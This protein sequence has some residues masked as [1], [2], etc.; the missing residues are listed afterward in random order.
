MKLFAKKKSGD[1]AAPDAI[2]DDGK[3]ELASFTNG[4]LLGSKVVSVLVLVAIACGPVAIGMITAR[5]QA[6]APV[7]AATEPGEL[8]PLQQATGSFAI[9]FVGS[10]LSA[11]K[12]DS[13]ALEAY[14]TTAPPGLGDVP[15][16]YR[17]LAVVE[18]APA[19]DAMTV[20][21][22]VGADVMEQG[23]EE[24]PAWVRRYYEVVVNTASDR[25]SAVGYPAPIVG[26]QSTAGATGLGLNS[27]LASNSPAVETIQLMLAAYLIGQGSTSS[28]LTPGVT[29]PAIT[30]A[31]F[32]LLNSVSFYADEQPAASP[33]DGDST[34]VQ[35]LVTL[36]TAEGRTVTAMYFVD[37]TARAGR[38]EVTSLSTSQSSSTAQADE[39]PAPTPSSIDDP[40]EG[41]DR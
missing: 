40:T 14:V 27:Q 13:T 30:P 31:P 38:W 11:T 26:P 17:N 34:L 35:A 41:E 19:D 16:E 21:V 2:V 25:L 36:Q 22:M 3:V 10:W 37:L 24:E 12:S 20:T 18:T 7:A 23:A 1:E 9:G 6:A 32:V 8:A 28:Y 33:A 15:F 29:I 5:G 39:S 4:S